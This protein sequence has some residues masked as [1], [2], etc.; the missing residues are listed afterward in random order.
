MGER[1]NSWL[2][3]VRRHLTPE[4][5]AYLKLGLHSELR[6]HYGDVE[7]L[8]RPLL[9][10]RFLLDHRKDKSETE[11]LK[12]FFHALKELGSNLRGKYVLQRGLEDYELTHPGPLDHTSQEFDFY[13]LLMKIVTKI[14]KDSE[15]CNDV[16]TRFAKYRCMDMNH[17]NIENLAELFI[18]L[19]QKDLIAPE[20]TSKL[21]R[22]LYKCK[23]WECLEILKNYYDK[24]IGL[25]LASNVEKALQKHIMHHSELNAP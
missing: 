19:C 13:V 15:L 11:V 10:Y 4:A 21:E 7:K 25:K 6:H 22:T 5:F 9:L 20:N 24:S 12:M 16:K 17:R 18:Q 1:F 8:D 14:V 23:A 3:C 2:E